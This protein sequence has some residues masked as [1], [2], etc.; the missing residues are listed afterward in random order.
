MAADTTTTLS[1]EED[2]QLPSDSK[3]DVRTAEVEEID[4][5]ALKRYV[6]AWA[7]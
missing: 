1:K 4:P 2:G 6:A 5:V 3:C 7:R